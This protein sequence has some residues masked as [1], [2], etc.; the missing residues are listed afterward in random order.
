[1][2]TGAPNVAA[3]NAP[4]ATLPSAG[5]PAGQP[6]GT[7]LPQPG[8]AI[9]PPNLP[10]GMT[11]GAFSMGAQPGAPS[12]PGFMAPPPGANPGALAKAGSASVP[13]GFGANNGANNPYAAFFQNAP[14]SGTSSKVADLMASIMNS[15]PTTP[16]PKASSYPQIQPSPIIGAT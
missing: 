8:G 3:L 12:A 2:G 6:G 14:A 15:T 11:P 7:Q 5:I 1:M 16:L 9:A 4:G 10:G 13:F